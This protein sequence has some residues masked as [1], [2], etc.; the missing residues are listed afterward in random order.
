MTREEE[1]ASFE[2][3]RQESLDV[4]QETQAQLKDLDQT[5][6]LAG[7]GSKATPI[8]E[9]AFKILQENIMPAS[10]FASSQDGKS[11]TTATMADGH[12][13]IPCGKAGGGIR[14]SA[15]PVTI[16]HDE[17]ASQVRVN[18]Y[19][20]EIITMRILEGVKDSLNNPERIYDIDNP[21]DQKILMEA[22][23]GELKQY[24]RA[25]TEYNQDHKFDRLKNAMYS[26]KYYNSPEYNALI[27][28]EYS[29]LKGIQPFLAFYKDQEE[30]W[31]GLRKYGLDIF[32]KKGRDGK[33]LFEALQCLHVFIDNIVIPVH[34]EFMSLT[35]TAIIDAPGTLVN[36]FDT[37]RAIDAARNA[38]V[39]LFLMRGDRQLKEEDLNMLRTLRN[40][41]MASKVCFA[42]NFR[43]NPLI[44]RNNI[45]KT[46]L[47]QLE[48]EGYTA[49]HQRKFL[50]YNA[51]LA[52]RSA[53]GTLI[54]NGE[55]DDLTS[56]AILEDSAKRFMT[57]KKVKEA[58]VAKL[59]NAKKFAEEAN[60]PDK[61]DKEIEE[62]SEK[63]RMCLEEYIAD[64]KENYLHDTEVI[65]DAWQKTTLKVLRSIDADACADLLTEKGLC[66][67]TTEAILAVSKWP[68]MIKKL[69]EHVMTKRTAGILR[70]LGA[71]PVFKA[72]EEVESALSQREQAIVGDEEAAKKSYEE[73]SRLLEKFNKGAEEIL[74]DKFTSSID[75][76][77]ANDYYD[78]VI[79]EAIDEAA[80]QASPEV[81][82]STGFVGNVKNIWHKI[83]GGDS[84][85]TICE[86]I[87]RNKYEAVMYE[88]GNRWSLELEES[89][90]YKEQIRKNV[91]NTERE[92]AA[93]W[94][95]LGLDKNDLLRN[96]KPII[97]NLSGFISRD[98]SRSDIQVA[99]NTA[100][101][102][103]YDIGDAVKSLL[104]GFAVFVGM[105]WVYFVLLPADFIIPGFAE[106]V[107]F[108]ASAVAGL[109][110]TLSRTMRDK[111]IKR[112]SDEIAT[113]LRASITKNKRQIIA[114]LIE[115][116]MD[117]TPP[118]PG[119]SVIRNFYITVFNIMLNSQKDALKAEY[120]KRLSILRMSTDLREK[121]AEKAKD[122]RENHIA[123]LREKLGKILDKITA[124]WGTGEI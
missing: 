50:Y 96:V 20:K 99:I 48:S 58:S 55:L 97:S 91:R 45:E 2:K 34:S 52:L 114:K 117:T 84:L 27:N 56:G 18:V 82:D 80:E 12:E 1:L 95:K 116:K 37:K 38:A 47:S 54:L 10:L 32:N 42:V 67:E 74:E 13:I 57:L 8:I 72:I 51:F 30:R 70:D 69:R 22:L 110:Y 62:C 87:I 122:W 93:L 92:M 103:S 16:Y 63:S 59:R 36:S 21:S 40:A 53:Q 108:V 35:R 28:G 118:Q 106:I 29:T 31:A 107:I 100:L 76:A 104:A 4:M 83:V 33:P 85:K 119:I 66:A 26:L 65:K 43:K 102:M 24:Q 88:L 111:R 17:Y 19:P 39:V 120:E 112:L 64:L 49:E 90:I 77:I 98:I 60:D 81:F 15:V 123:P 124:I 6:E 7:I 46:I 14:T 79:L 115:G 78:E 86:R 109:V 25:P 3:L 5:Q 44:I 121:I 101:S 41:G 94:E 71:Q 89:E 105:G 113:G 68:D 75:K 11:T 9:Q 23:E 61:T 73:A